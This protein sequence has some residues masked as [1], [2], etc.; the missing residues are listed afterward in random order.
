MR[1]NL[2]IMTTACLTMMALSIPA[3][4]LTYDFAGADQALFGSPT[5]ADPVTV[6]PTH[7]TKNI[8]RSKDSAFIPPTFGAPSADTP[9]TGTLLT[10]NLS[11]VAPMQLG[12][13]KY[14]WNGSSAEN[15]LTAPGGS[16]AI[17]MPP[18][19]SGAVASTGTDDN[20]NFSVTSK[21]NV[22]ATDLTR[23]DGSIGL[24]KIPAID[25]SVKVYDGTTTANMKKGATHFTETSYWDGNV[26][27]AAHNRSSYF[28]KI[29][30]L[31]SGDK[32]TYSTNI[33]TR[34][35]EVVSVYKIDDD[36]TSCLNDS[37][38][39]RLTLVTCVEN[40]SAYRWCVIAKETS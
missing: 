30:K 16:G 27:M 1:K 26:A 28:G 15:S 22:T 20:S 14:T 33:G 10:P 32:I 25:V 12:S 21:K 13:D 19:V 2:M 31:K 11:G 24:L 37:T 34:K 39:N 8:N 9:G 17:V 3:S 5:S 38:E 36:D 40:Q 23:D 18:S 7:D 29:Y 35:Y 6:V 4:A